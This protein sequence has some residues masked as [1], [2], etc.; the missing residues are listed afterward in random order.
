MDLGIGIER[1]FEAHHL[2]SG[3][4]HIGIK[5]GADA[6]ERRRSKRDRRGGVGRRAPGWTRTTYLCG[7]AGPTNLWALPMHLEVDCLTGMS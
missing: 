5:A 1:R 4:G 7:S 2:P 3:G 6:G